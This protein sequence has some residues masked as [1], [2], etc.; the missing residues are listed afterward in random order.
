VLK[1]A[2]NLCNPCSVNEA[3][4]FKDLLITQVKKGGNLGSRVKLRSEGKKKKPELP[5]LKMEQSTG[6]TSRNQICRKKSLK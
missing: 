2:S 5:V 1:I 3:E 6:I 4:C